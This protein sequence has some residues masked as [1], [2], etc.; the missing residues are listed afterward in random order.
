[1]SFFKYG[2]DDLIN[3]LH[4]ILNE[5]FQLEYFPKKWSDSFII[6]LHKKG[7][8]NNVENYRGIS[9]LSHL[10]KLFTRVLSNRL[11]EWAE[12]YNV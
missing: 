5:I 6:P 9:L 11:N 7:N 10:G 1:M 8:V 2:V 4:A 3:Y 12:N